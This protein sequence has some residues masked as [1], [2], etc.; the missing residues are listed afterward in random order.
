MPVAYPSENL[1]YKWTNTMIESMDQLVEKLT[2]H[3]GDLLLEEIRS[4]IYH[5]AP[6]LSQSEL[7]LIAD[8]TPRHFHHMKK[9]LRPP[10]EEM[11]LGSAAH[12]AILEP[13]RFVD[14][15]RMLQP[16]NK[17]TKAGREEVKA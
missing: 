14:T 9:A 4:E 11:K 1:I 3:N 2:A 8:K 6:A 15:Y 5:A 7:K 13:D 16:I 12:M 10:S 17:R